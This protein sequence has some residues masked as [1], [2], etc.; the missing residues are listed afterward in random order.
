VLGTCNLIFLSSVSALN[1]DVARHWQDL[2]KAFAQKRTK[3]DGTLW[4]LHV[5]W[6]KALLFYWLLQILGAISI[7]YGAL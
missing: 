4:Q 2:T 6:F 1:L 7:V 5:F 3:E